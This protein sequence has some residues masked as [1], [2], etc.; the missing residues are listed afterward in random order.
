M[1]YG[2]PTAAAI[3]LLAWGGIEFKRGYVASKELGNLLAAIKW[4]T[5]YLLRCHVNSNEF[6]VQVTFR[7]ELE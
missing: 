2:F 4:G 6:Y 5:D 7:F 3:S 1:K